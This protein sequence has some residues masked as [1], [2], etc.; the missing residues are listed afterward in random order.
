MGTPFAPVDLPIT[1]A[2][3][4]VVIPPA[5]TPNVLSAA[6]E[7]RMDT[8]L[9]GLVKVM[10]FGALPLLLLLKLMVNAVEAALPIPK[11]VTLDPAPGTPLGVQLPAVAQTPR[12]APLQA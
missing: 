7:L 5:P 10:E 9:V 3:V 2:P 6:L 8:E 11:I 1:T 12:D 4:P